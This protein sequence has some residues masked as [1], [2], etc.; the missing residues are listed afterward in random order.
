MIEMSGTKLDR[1][2]VDAILEKGS[3]R[4]SVMMRSHSRM[5]SSASRL[6]F[7]SGGLNQDD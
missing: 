5:M 3:K 4:N 6:S 1:E 7:K 2:R